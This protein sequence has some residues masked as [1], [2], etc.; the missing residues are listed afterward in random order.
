[1]GEIKK[2]ILARR[3]RY[4]F[5]G[6]MSIEDDKVVEIVDFALTNVP[7]SFNSQ[8]ARVILL[9]G[10]QHTQLWDIVKETLRKGMAPEAFVKT[11]QK[12]DTSF[13]SAHGTILFFEDQSVVEGLQKQFPIYADNFP[14]WSLQSSGMVQYTVW[15]MLAEVGV[16]ASLQHYNPLIDEE[17]KAKW[18]V[19]ASWRLMSQMPFGNATDTPGEKSVMPLDERRK[20]FK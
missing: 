7:S 13:A 15:T 10:P 12:I 11:Q 9:F 19:P 5:G 8:T 4:A 16:G 17:V 1:M 2:A 14:L 3:S 6:K 20:I 18:N